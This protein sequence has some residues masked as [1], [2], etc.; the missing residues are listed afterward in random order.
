MLFVTLTKVGVKK[1][2]QM[3]NQNFLFTFLAYQTVIKN[4]RKDPK[5]PKAKYGLI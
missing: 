3:L 2:D 4:R 1:F 5:K